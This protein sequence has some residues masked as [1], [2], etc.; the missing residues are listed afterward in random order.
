M[1]LKTK[2]L[3]AAA[4]TLA[5]GLGPAA[6]AVQPSTSGQLGVG[7]TIY[8]QMGGNPGDGAT[9]PREIGAADAGHAFGIK[10]VE[11]FSAWKPETM[12]AQFRQA[13]AAHPTCIA[14]T[15]HPGDAAFAPLIAQAEQQGV[16]VT[17]GNTP[18]PAAAKEYGAKGFGYAGVDLYV[19]GEI[20]AQALLDAGLKAG[21]VALE[22][23]IFN[24]TERSQSDRGLRDTLAKA[25][26]KVTTLEISSQV[27]A[28]PSLAVP[29]LVAFI[30]SHPGLKAIG[31]QHGGVTAF[32]PQALKLAGKTPGQ[33]LV[34][35]ID[36]APA[37]ISGLQSK[38]ISATLDQQL[39]L[40]GFLPVTQCVLSAAYHF[41]G[42]TINTGAGV[43]TP[44]SIEALIPLIKRGIR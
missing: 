7:M 16:L 21:D 35:G 28:D 4:S 42:L 22:Y 34:G 18:L 32:I 17:V 13:L 9:L 20:T 24:E 33:V 11:Q 43:E 23:G 37:T 38:Y 36:L 10:V 12:L 41:S 2:L 6:Q 31:T 29:V 3:L 15:G 26:V 27:D 5:V 30:E 39:Y 1:T 25:G 14:I 44:A 40:Q 19:G 8:M